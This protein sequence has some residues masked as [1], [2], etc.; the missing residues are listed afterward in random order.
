MKK[1]I[2]DS[3]LRFKRQE[4]ALKVTKEIVLKFI[5]TGRL[6]PASFPEIFQHIYKEIAKNLDLDS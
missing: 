5:E 6:T 3:L 4:L 2:D 1:N